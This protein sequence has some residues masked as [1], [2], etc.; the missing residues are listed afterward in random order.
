MPVDLLRGES[1][2][3]SLN[4]KCFSS[5]MKKMT[6]FA[7]NI[8]AS[9]SVLAEIRHQLQFY[10]WQSCHLFYPADLTLCLVLELLSK[11]PG[12]FL[13]C[14]TRTSIWWQ[15]EL[16]AVKICLQK[17]DACGLLLNISKAD[18]FQTCLIKGLL[19]SHLGTSFREGPRHAGPLGKGSSLDSCGKENCKIIVQIWAKA[20]CDVSTEEPAFAFWHWCCSQYLLKSTVTLSGEVFGLYLSTRLTKNCRVISLP[21]EVCALGE[22]TPRTVTHQFV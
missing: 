2:L 11:N 15:S 1:A 7:F 10:P 4:V 22:N 6:P 3:C 5:N 20:T 9:H 18:F 13:F 21:M 8:A 14:C 16:I 12:Q 17:Q 19:T